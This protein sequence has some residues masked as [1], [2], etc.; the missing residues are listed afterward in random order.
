MNTIAEFHIQQMLESLKKK[1]M[2]CFVFVRCVGSRKPENASR[3]QIIEV[4]AKLDTGIIVIYTTHISL[5][6]ISLICFHMSYINVCL[7]VPQI[8]YFCYRY[9][10]K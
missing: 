10:V 1:N 4:Y 7:F 6:Q 9:I 2:L 5:E 8:P 3:N